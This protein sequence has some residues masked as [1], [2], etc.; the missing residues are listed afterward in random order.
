MMLGNS[1]E[2]TVFRVTQKY[3]G[4]RLD[5]FLAEQLP[6]FSRTYIQKLIKNGNVLVD[7]KAAKPRHNVKTGETVTFDIPSPEPA[8]PTPQKIAVDVVYEDEHL[9]VIN[10]PAGMVVH[11]AAGVKDGTLVN[12]LLYHCKDLS[13]IGGVKRPG[14]VHRLDKNTSG[15]LVVA[16]HDASHKGLS[17]QLSERTMKRIY[18]ALVFGEMPLESG[19]IEYPVGRDPHHREKMTV[20]FTKG[21]DAVSAYYVVRRFHH[22]TLLAVSLGTGRTHQI[23]VHLSHINFPVVGDGQYGV[24]PTGI[25]SNIP[26]HEGTL[27]QAIA[28]QKRQLL[29]AACLS[30]THPVTG[31]LKSFYA[32]LPSDFETFLKILEC[33][34]LSSGLPVAFPS[35]A[36]QIIDTSQ[37]SGDRITN[38]KMA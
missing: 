20:T 14:I 35:I 6:D 8:A 11:P 17:K 38:R 23:R 18:L 33:P 16:K 32:P 22:F 9:L 29:H 34:I 3:S 31:K 37:S 7:S 21:R 5:K 1:S 36:K 19:R 4:A 10:K 24:N 28:H 12:A 25:M 2:K 13:G 27:R 15:L 30:F 26:S